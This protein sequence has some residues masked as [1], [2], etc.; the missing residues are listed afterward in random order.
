MYT[1]L[2]VAAG[3]C[4]DNDYLASLFENIRY[5]DE[6]TTSNASQFTCTRINTSFSGRINSEFC[7]TIQNPLTGVTSADSAEP[8]QCVLWM[9]IDESFSFNQSLEDRRITGFA[10]TMK[11][12]CD[13]VTVDTINSFEVSG[14]IIQASFSCPPGS[15]IQVCY[16]SRLTSSEFL[17]G[18]VTVDLCAALT[19]F[20]A[21]PAAASTELFIPPPID[22]ECCYGRDAIHLALSNIERLRGRLSASG[23]VPACQEFEFPD[24]LDHTNLYDAGNPTP[25][26]MIGVVRVCATNTADRGSDQIIRINPR[27]ECGGEQFTCI[28][29]ALLLPAPDDSAGQPARQRCINVPIVACGICPAG[30]TLNTSVFAVTECDEEIGTLGGSQV[31]INLERQRYC[32]WTF[33]PVLTDF[34]D[35][36]VQSLPQRCL[37]SA[38]FEQLHTDMEQLNAVCESLA[39]VTVDPEGVTGELVGEGTVLVLKPA[40]PWP[41]L[42]DP[43]N[44]DPVPEKKVFI[45]AIL[46]ACGPRLSGS[47]IPSGQSVI[48][49]SAIIECGGAEVARV[50]DAWVMTLNG[51]YQRCERLPDLIR[52]VTCP[53]DQDLTIRFD[54]GAGGVAGTYTLEYDIK[55]TCIS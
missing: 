36:N 27:V 39:D 43:T 52:C 13:G 35:A 22:S 51:Q 30:S 49:F 16:N 18:T 4:I 24:L 8:V 46:Q 38:V 20:G 34:G 21:T 14:S 45:N 12:T 37:P 41:P 55:M 19:C 53:I 29:G 32:L 25:F 3:D 48:G 9:V 11:V 50:N 40:Q 26:L 1:P 23:Q 5:F 6:C 2:P 54:R 7:T 10:R 17:S 42:N 44:T 28:G 33:E 15:E 47:Q 31:T